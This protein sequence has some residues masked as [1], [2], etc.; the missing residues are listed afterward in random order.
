MIDLIKDR[1]EEYETRDPVQKMNAV[2]EILQEI[3]L[4]GLWRTGFFEKAG[5]DHLSGQTGG[6]LP[7][8]YPG[9]CE[10]DPGRSTGCGAYPELERH[11]RDSGGQTGNGSAA[12]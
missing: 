10:S 6:Q 7:A 11:G 2:K 12:G 1:L 4:F 3:A 8:V 9:P 5:T